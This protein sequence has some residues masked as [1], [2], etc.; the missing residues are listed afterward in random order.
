MRDTVD[1]WLNPPPKPVELVAQ[2]QEMTEIRQRAEAQLAARDQ[3]WLE[4]IDGLRRD[5][6]QLRGVR[7]TAKSVDTR[8]YHLWLLLRQTAD[9]ST[10]YA[11]DSITPVE[12]MLGAE[13]AAAL[14]DALI[15]HWRLW[16]PT[17]KSA[18]ATNER[19]QISELDCMGI[20]GVSLETR[21]RPHWA[22]RLSSDEAALAARYATLEINGFPSWFAELADRSP[23][24]PNRGSSS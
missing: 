6:N 15:E 14:R 9:T 1:T 17:L 8:L 13:V 3:S 22:E 7:P 12:P 21:T 2:E 4:F 18:R 20:A 19:N 24:C 11:I 10:Y 5:P 23:E 16:Q